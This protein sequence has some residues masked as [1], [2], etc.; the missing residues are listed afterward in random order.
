MGPNAVAYSVRISAPVGVSSSDWMP[1]EYTGAF[2]NSD[3][4]AG[5]GTGNTPCADF[6]HAA[7]DVDRRDDD[8]IGVEP[9]EREHGADDVDDRV[10]RADFVQVD[11]VDRHAVNRGFRL[12]E[13]RNILIALRLA[14]RRS[15]T[16][17]SIAAIDLV[18]RV[19]TAHRADDD[20]LVRDRR[21]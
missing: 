14:G 3:S 2:F 12:A 15:T 16:D 17:R 7:A 21:C 19:M 1:L 9:F 10:E 6:D 8:A 18:Q 4:V 11:L 5:A 20:A 13:P